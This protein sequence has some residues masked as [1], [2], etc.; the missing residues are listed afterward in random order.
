M[1]NLAYIKANGKTYRPQK[2]GVKNENKRQGN[3]P[4]CIINKLWFGRFEIL[5]YSENYQY[6]KGGYAIGD[7]DK[8]NRRIILYPF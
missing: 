4:V 3:Y 7:E 8:P 1:K 5:Y 6:E 2:A